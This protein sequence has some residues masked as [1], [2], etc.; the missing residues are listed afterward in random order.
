MSKTCY[1]PKIDDKILKIIDRDKETR[2]NMLVGEIGNLLTIQL[3]KK[4]KNLK[5]IES[6]GI[7]RNH[8]GDLW[9]SKSH[10]WVALPVKSC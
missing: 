8:L 6:M 1:D 9:K 7:R 4:E 3:R 10:T 5:K 2:F